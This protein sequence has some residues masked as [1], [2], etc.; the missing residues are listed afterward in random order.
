MLVVVY[1]LYNTFT[2]ELKSN[3]SV[4]G[5]LDECAC[6]CDYFH[7]TFSSH[8]SRNGYQVG[9]SKVSDTLNI[10]IVYL[11]GRIRSIQLVG[12]VTNN[13]QHWTVARECVIITLFFGR[14]CHTEQRRL[15]AS[16]SERCAQCGE[17]RW[18][19][20]RKPH[21]TVLSC[22]I[23]NLCRAYGTQRAYNLSP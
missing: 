11:Y 12:N 4:R 7:F 13:S 10:R 20:M 2:A 9:E 18:L 17:D 19:Q 1:T 22:C 15:R 14:V 16:N 5:L 21:K 8:G 3:L 6:I 23:I